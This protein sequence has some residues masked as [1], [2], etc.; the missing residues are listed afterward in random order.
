MGVKMFVEQNID[1]INQAIENEYKKM[2]STHGAK[3]HTEHEGYA[4]LKEEIEEA[5]EEV[6]IINDFFSRL[7]IN[8]KKNE[9]FVCELK[10]IKGRA[11]FL[12]QEA[13]QV[14]AVCQKFL[15]TL[16]GEIKEND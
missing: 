2:C 3:Y 7:W 15:N 6:K 5:E 4:V 12:A 14:S 10:G 13:C 8:I 9:H 1:L 16:Q 11:E